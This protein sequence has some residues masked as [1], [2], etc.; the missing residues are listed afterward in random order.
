[1]KSQQRERPH[2]PATI[3]QNERNS[4]NFKN[5]KICKEVAKVNVI[6]CNQR[7]GKPDREE[8]KR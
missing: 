5:F 4:K 1:M 3:K 8:E 6:Y 7:K 2:K